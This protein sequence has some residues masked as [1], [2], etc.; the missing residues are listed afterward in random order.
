MKRASIRR[1]QL[2]RRA[3]V[4]AAFLA[5]ALVGSP[6]ATADSPQDIL[7]IV[8]ASVKNEKVTRDELKAIFLKKRA[9]WGNGVRAVPVHSNNAAL[10][11]DFRERLLQMSEGEELRY[12]QQFQIQKGEAKPVAFGNT[13]KAVFQLRGAVSYIYRSQYREGATNVILVLPAGG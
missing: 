1:Q 10:R 5:V 2:M 13:L 9:S 12:W 4:F 7:V 8:N 6:P 3:T 11:D